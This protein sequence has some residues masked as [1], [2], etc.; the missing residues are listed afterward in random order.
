MSKPA[1]LDISPDVLYGIAQLAI[2]QLDGIRPIQPSVR[3]GEILT[4]RRAKGI[5]IERDGA[6]V[7]VALT[8]AVDYGVEIPK[9]AKAAQ[10]AVREGVASMTGLLVKSVDVNVEA[11]ELREAEQGG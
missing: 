11:V 3:V 10:R 9:V 1:D 5:A 8:V 4:R 2:E 7:T 6:E